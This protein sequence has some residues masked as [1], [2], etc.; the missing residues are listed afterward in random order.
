MGLIKERC[1]LLPDF[2]TQGIFFFEAPTSYDEAAVKPK[3][4]DTK[5]DYFDSIIANLKKWTA[6]TRLQL[7]KFL[8][9]WRWKKILKSGELQMIFRVMLVGSKTGPAVFV[10]AE[11]IGK[12]ATVKRIEN[13]VKVF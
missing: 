6:G 2:Y 7:K 9:R 1:T 3:W 13:A 5:K 10:I 8:N 4:D 11:T 12:E